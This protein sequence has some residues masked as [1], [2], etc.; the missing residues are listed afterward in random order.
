MAA[1]AFDKRCR[2]IEQL[3]S[4]DSMLENYTATAEATDSSLI[5]WPVTSYLFSDQMRPITSSGILAPGH[6]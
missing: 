6:F 1:K 5:S 2:T 3:L 4:N